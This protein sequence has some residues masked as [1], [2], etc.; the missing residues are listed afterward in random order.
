MPNA[1]THHKVATFVG[2]AAGLYSAR[3]E[4]S[5]AVVLARILGSVLA[6]N[7]GA[8]LPDVLEPAFHSHHR[9]FFHSMVALAGTT[10]A[11]IQ[12]PEGMQDWRGERVAEAERLRARRHALPSDDPSRLGLWIAEMC[13]E[14]L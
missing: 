14:A 6:A 8:A 4:P 11:S 5:A 2:I 3:N 12:A 13:E 10:G 7:L 1:R 9:K